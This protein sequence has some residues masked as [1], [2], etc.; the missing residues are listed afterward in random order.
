MTH[1]TLDKE[2]RIKLGITDNLLRLSV[3]LEDIHDLI[4][5]LDWALSKV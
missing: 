2:R 5:D 4:R 3:G 1:I